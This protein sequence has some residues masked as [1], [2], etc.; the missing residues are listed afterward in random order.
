MNMSTIVQPKNEVCV[1]EDDPD[2]NIVLE[3][4]LEGKANYIISG[5]EHLLK[6]KKYEGTIIVKA[7]EFLDINP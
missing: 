1:I 3:C 7:Q 6:L 5:D 4:G 2:D